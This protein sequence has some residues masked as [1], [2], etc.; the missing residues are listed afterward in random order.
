MAGGPDPQ[1]YVHVRVVMGMIL[2]LCITR[3]LSGFAKFIQ[4]PRD[5]VASPLHLAWAGNML[6]S[7]ILFWWWEFRLSGIHWTFIVYV[8]IL[9]YA[10]LFYF[11][12]AL[13]F[14]DYLGEYADY[15]QYFF[16]KRRWFFGL[17]SLSYLMDVGDTLL[18]GGDYVQLVG[19]FELAAT[20]VL[21]AGALVAMA[22]RSRAYHAS[23]LLLTVLDHFFWIGWLLNT[24]T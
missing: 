22:V 21:V 23:Y 1:L 19:T 11:M 15:D 24:L 13:L 20:V 8:F 14:P 5:H 4:H 3:L 6:V 7:A 18:K 10:S 17:L 16:A 9:S 12:C 2:G